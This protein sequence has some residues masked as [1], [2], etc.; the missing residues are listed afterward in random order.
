MDDSVLADVDVV[1][2]TVESVVPLEGGERVA[3]LKIVEEIQAG[4]SGRLLLPEQVPK[5]LLPY[6]AEWHRDQ[7]PIR[8]CEKSRRIGYSWGALA[9]EAAIEAS[10]APDAGGMDQFYMGYNMLMAAEFIGD[11]AFFA[12]AYGMAISNIDV[13][14]ET[15]VIRDE[16]R[17]IVTYKVQFASGHKIEALSSNPHNW[18]SRQGHARIDEAAFHKNLK[19][20]VKGALAFKMWGGRIDV[21]STHNG[22]DNDFNELLKDVKAKKLP[23]S[24]HRITFDDALRQGFYKR[25]CL[26]KLKKPWSQSDEDDYRAATYADYP[27]SDDAQEELD[28]IAKRGSGAYFTRMLIEFCQEDGIPVIRF[29]QPAEYVLDQDRATIAAKWIADVL[30]PLIDAM[31]GKRTVFGQ[32]FGRDGDLSVVWP[33]QQIAPLKWRT[34]FILEMRRIPFDV[35]RQVVKFLLE[36]LP[37]F[38][39][40]KFDARGNGQSHAEAALQ[41]RGPQQIDCV[42]ATPQWY[43]EWFPKYRQAYEDQ[44]IIVPKSEDV[45]ADHRSVV[46]VKGAPSMSD[47]RTKGSDGEGRHGDSAIAGLLAWAATQTEGQPAFGVTIEDNQADDYESERSSVFGLLS[48]RTR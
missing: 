46:L 12:R 23:W 37:L 42:M 18:R 19:E 20:V 24:L 38:H 13:W 22:E 6:Q 3:A 7:A 34:P 21:V 2:A 9:A 39:H 14:K 36:E 28:C 31:P 33:L 8:I 47:K 27:S 4:R 32:D 41:L 10:A 40:A 17:D 30:K 29:S 44:S 43:A 1:E 45:I 16:R 25:V 35:Q 26:V 5:I 15:I 48:G 11:A